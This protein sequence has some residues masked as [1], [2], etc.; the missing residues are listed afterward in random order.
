M[1]NR[2]HN[3]NMSY[4]KDRVLVGSC[5][6]NTFAWVHVSGY[7][8]WNTCSCLKLFCVYVCRTFEPTRLVV[9]DTE[10]FNEN[11]HKR[12]WPQVAFAL[13]SFEKF[14]LSLKKY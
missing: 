4:N 8:E 12:V 1:C 5:C 6:Q 14:T 9:K 2:L 3:A 13:S 11:Y 7:L 10:Y